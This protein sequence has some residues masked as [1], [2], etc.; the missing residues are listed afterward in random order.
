MFSNNIRLHLKSLI[1]VQFNKSYSG[2]EEG[3]FAFHYDWRM[4]YGGKFRAFLG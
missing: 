1:G 4:L 3:E 2:S